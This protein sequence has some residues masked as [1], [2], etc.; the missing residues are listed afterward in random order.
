[1]SKLK[2]A[3]ILFLMVGCIMPMFIGAL[4][5]ATHFSQLVIPEIKEILQ[6]EIVIFG[7]SQPIWNTW[8]I[9][10]F[11]MGA[12]FI[13]IGLLNISI[14][15]NLSKM[16]YPPVFPILAMIIYQLCVTY[17]GYEYEQGFQLYG[18]MVG[19]VFLLICLMLTLR[20]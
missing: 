13:I 16:E 10:S 9:V 19:T 15:R 11:M 14:F 6:S 3:R 2:T 18:G 17:V 5:T 4:H 20:K 1:M 8:G 7:V 12:S